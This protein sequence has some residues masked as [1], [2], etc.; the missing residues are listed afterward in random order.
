MLNLVAQLL[1]VS[2]THSGHAVSGYEIGLIK[3]RTTCIDNS[4]S[5]ILD[6]FAKNITLNDICKFAAMSR[7]SFTTSFYSTV[8]QTCNTYITALK[9]RKAFYL[10]LQPEKRVSE[11]A[12]ECGFYDGSHLYRKCIELYGASPL[13]LRKN[14]SQWLREYGDALYKKS[15]RK[16]SWAIPF[17]EEA[18]E[19]HRRKMSIY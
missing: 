19:N 4:M 12:K 2:V 6:N 9:M 3:N 5:Y 17:T 11:V 10:L 14:A 13:Y 18:L 15:I 8:G 1:T 7:S 16:S